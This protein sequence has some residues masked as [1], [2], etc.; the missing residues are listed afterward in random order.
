MKIIAT[1]VLS[2]L[3]AGCAEQIDETYA[4]YAEAQSAGAVKRGWVPTFVPSSATDIVDSHDLDTNRQ[5]LKFNLPPSSIGEMVVG[6]RVVSANDQDALTELLSEHGLG[7]SSPGYV[8]CSEV[9]NGA[10]VVD[11]EL[12][13]AVY[14]T[15]VTWADDDCF[16][17]VSNDVP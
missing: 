3:M 5:T 13:R 16:S 7:Q 17:S 9:Q 6:L 12:G 4:T 8:V 1:T 15:T 2:L 10:L 11:P 14:D